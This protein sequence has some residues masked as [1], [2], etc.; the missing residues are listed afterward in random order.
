MLKFLGRVC[1]LADG[2]PPPK[3]DIRVRG[4]PPEFEPIHISL[5]IFNDDQPI[6]QSRNW[7]C[8]IA[9]REDAEAFCDANDGKFDRGRF[10]C[11]VPGM[12][13]TTQTIM[14]KWIAADNVISHTLDAGREFDVFRYI[15]T[16]LRRLRLIK[17]E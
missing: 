12:R 5:E 6:V 4:N 17:K 8:I 2:Q 7:T 10:F 13:V 16:R 3:F 14:E 1:G 9:W 15:R 11:L